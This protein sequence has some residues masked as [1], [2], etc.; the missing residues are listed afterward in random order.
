[1]QF[2]GPKTHQI[3]DGLISE[4]FSLQ[5]QQNLYPEHILFRWIV[6][7]IVIWHIFLEMEKLF[8]RLIHL[9]LLVFIDFLNLAMLSFY[10]KNY[11]SILS[12]S[13]VALF[14][15]NCIYYNPDY[16]RPMKPFFIEIPNFWAWTDNL[17]R[18]ILGHFGYF[19]PD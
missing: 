2:H 9:Y 13:A 3:K 5:R 6:L 7:R 15:G 10:W 8:L 11:L 18:Y 16:G 4:S 19:R 17:G 12:S 14:Y 1:M